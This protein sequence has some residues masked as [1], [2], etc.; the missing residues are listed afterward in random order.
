MAKR[1]KRKA[2]ALPGA[3]GSRERGALPGSAFA[4][5]RQRKYP[6][7]VRGPGGTLVPSGSHASNA[8]ARAAQQLTLGNLSIAQHDRIVRKADAVLRKCKA[9]GGKRTQLTQEQ[10]LEIALREAVK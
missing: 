10:R 2:C 8:K 1:G 7:Y 4:L 3:I 6:L 9:T 5:E